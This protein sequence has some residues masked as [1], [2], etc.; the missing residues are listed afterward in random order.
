[1]SFGGVR[2]LSAATDAL[3]EQ[4]TFDDLAADTLAA[5]QDT[6]KPEFLIAK[7]VVFGSLE[8]VVVSHK[9]FCQDPLSPNKNFIVIQGKGHISVCKPDKVYTRPVEIV[10]SV[11]S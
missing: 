1:M 2:A 11:L 9:P 8:A 10:A 3:S 7:K 4:S 6:P 5:L